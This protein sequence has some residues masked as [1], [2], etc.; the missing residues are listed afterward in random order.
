MVLDKIGSK[1]PEAE[2]G[3]QLVS[4]VLYGT[5]YAMVVSTWQCPLFLHCALR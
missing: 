4:T 1:E 2:K 5:P 3:Y